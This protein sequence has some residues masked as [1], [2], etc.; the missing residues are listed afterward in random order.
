M[1]LPAER[2][3]LADIPEILNPASKPVLFKNTI[4]ELLA[5]AINPWLLADIDPDRVRHGPRTPADDLRRV[6]RAA[7]RQ[8]FYDVDLPVPENPCWLVQTE[9]AGLERFGDQPVAEL[10]QVEPQPGEQSPLYGA[11]AVWGVGVYADGVGEAL[12]TK[13]G[14]WVTGAALAI[15][16][17]YGV[18][19]GGEWALIYG[20]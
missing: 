1:P 13:V 19:I 7:L 8:S 12:L 18:D 9:I 5:L 3:P 17:R 20:P 2:Q 11:W 16:Q 6:A 4:G 10:L 14:P 15:R